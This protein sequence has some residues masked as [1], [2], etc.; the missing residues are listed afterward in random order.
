MWWKLFKFYIILEISPQSS[1]DESYEQSHD[2]QISLEFLKDNVSPFEDIKQHWISTFN[3]RKDIMKT[4]TIIQY[5]NAI[6]YLQQPDGYVLLT[7]DFNKMYPDREN[8]IYSNWP[9]LKT[10]ILK[11]SLEKGLTLDFPDEGNL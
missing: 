4:S 11:L 9:K 7:N 3:A 10:A 8:A 6:R 5:F 1:S 2:E